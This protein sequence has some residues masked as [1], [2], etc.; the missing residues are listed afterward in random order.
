VHGGSLDRLGDAGADRAGGAVHYPQL[1]CV[2]RGD[3]DRA[4]E[5]RTAAS[6]WKSSVHERARSL[7][8]RIN[9]GHVQTFQSDTKS[10]V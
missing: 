2:L 8:W 5:D 7:R 1:L 6:G 9:T 10:K 4:G 3:R